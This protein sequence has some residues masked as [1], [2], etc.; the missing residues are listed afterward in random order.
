MKL[1]GCE[2]IA[3]IILDDI[4]KKKKKNS[5]FSFFPSAGSTKKTISGSVIKHMSRL[6]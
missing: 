4:C 1:A 5:V 2:K 6:Q 3:Y